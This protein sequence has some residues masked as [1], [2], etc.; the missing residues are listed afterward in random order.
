M[1]HVTF[2]GGVFPH[3]RKRLTR[4]RELEEYLP[5]GELVYPLLQHIGGMAVPVVEVGERVLEGQMIAKASGDISVPVHASVSG[6]V[7]AIEPRMTVSGREIPS[8]VVENDGA[9]EQAPREELKS[10]REMEPGEKLRRIREAGIA[11]MGGAGFPTHVKLAVR[12]PKKIR[13][14][15]VNGTECERYMTSGYRRM[16]EEPE[17]LAE[18]LAMVVSLFGRAVG[19]I[20]VEDNKRDAITAL[21]LAVRSEARM[22]VR[23]F[24]TKYPQGAERQLIY[25]VTKRAINSEMLPADAGCIVDNVETLIGIHTAVVEGKPLTERVVTVSGDAIASPGNFKVLLGTSHEEL[26]EAAGGFS[27]EPEKLISGGPMMGF[28][29]VTA[30]A[31][32]T[33]TSSSILAFKED[34]VSRNPETACINCGRCVEVCPSRIIPSR[35]ADYAQRHDEESFT[36]MNGLECVERGSCSYV[37][38]AKRPLKQAIGSMRKTALANKRKK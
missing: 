33:K 8:I 29:M 7:K 4:D 32:V 21:Q 6:T 13:Y 26:I 2:K 35:L 14:V 23:V 37:C 17:R 5:K 30:D 1:G 25:A 24:E 18:G 9:Y 38:P 22:E 10:W 27:A 19:I 31:P 12:N 15:I 11:G 28:A 16:V 34:A 20:A 36:A 3:R